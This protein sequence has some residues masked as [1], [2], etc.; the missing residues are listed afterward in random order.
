[1]LCFLG[2]VAVTKFEK[3]HIRKSKA[4]KEVSNH[5][6][7][8]YKTLGFFADQKWLNISDFIRFN[9]ICIKLQLFPFWIPYPLQNLSAR[10]LLLPLISFSLLPFLCSPGNIGIKVQTNDYWYSEN[11]NFQLWPCF[12]WMDEWMNE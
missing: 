6:V 10:S 3:K 5:Y 4:I 7:K 2:S 8:L 12:V 9:L 1:M 11:T